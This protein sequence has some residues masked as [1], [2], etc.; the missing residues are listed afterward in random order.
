MHMLDGLTIAEAGRRFRT[1]ELSPLALTE[2][3]IETIESRNPTVNALATVTVTQA[4]EAAER[5]TTELRVGCDRGPLHGIPISL[6]DNIDVA[7]VRT[8]AGS[9]LYAHRVPEADSAVASALRNA[10]AVLIGHA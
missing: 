8:T 1:G 3:T 9:K 7:G 5:A 6:K 4:V 10:G 2:L